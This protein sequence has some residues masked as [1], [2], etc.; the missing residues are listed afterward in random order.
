ME[1]RAGQCGCSQ[2][3]LEQQA[4]DPGLDGRTACVLTE[5]IQE[6]ATEQTALPGKGTSITEVRRRGGPGLLLTPAAGCGEET[7]TGRDAAAAPLR[8]P[9]Q[10]GGGRRLQRPWLLLGERLTWGQ[11]N[12][13]RP[14]GPEILREMYI[15]LGKLRDYLSELLL[16]HL[17]CS[18][19]PSVVF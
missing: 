8:P 16:I 5:R 7:R 10:A 15:F 14:S 6:D 3:S 13:S 18:P 4:L 17:P 11:G 2:G 19:H 12:P 9:G 1:G